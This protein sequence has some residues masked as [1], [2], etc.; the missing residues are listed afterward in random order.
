M[1]IWSGALAARFCDRLYLLSHGRLHCCGGASE[2]L[3]REN[4][5]EVYGVDSRVDCD[6]GG[7]SVTSLSR[8]GDHHP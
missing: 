4:I 1:P 8:L 3:T 5:A 7:V 6:A 2:V